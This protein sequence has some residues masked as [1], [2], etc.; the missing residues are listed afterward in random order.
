VPRIIIT[1]DTHLGL[2]EY[3][4]I[5]KLVADIRARRPTLVTIAGDIGEGVENFGAVLEEFSSLGIP[6]AACAGNHD[7]WNNDKKYPSRLLWEQ[8]LPGI[9]E[10]TGTAWL[11]RE[12]VILRGVAIVGSTAWYD[13]SAQDPSV[14]APADECWRRKGETDADAWKIDWPWN[15]LEFCAMIEPGFR[16]RLQSASDD[17]RVKTIVVVTHSPIFEQQMTRKP[18]DF[19]WAFSNA[20]YGNLTF[21]EIVRQFPKVTHAI[22]G[23]THS[24]EEAT[25]EVGGHSLRAVTLNSQYG[26]P[27]FTVIDA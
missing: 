20:Y 16:A 10:S 1:S 19:K 24:G 22:A 5:R 14:K 23:H 4:R 6:L 13:Y 11:D 27:K 17:P 2:T 9:A 8:V 21:G 7:L 26:D 12:N 25:I 18:D 3:P 15:D